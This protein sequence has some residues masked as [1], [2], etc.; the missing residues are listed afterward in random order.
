[1]ADVQLNIS[2]EDWVTISGAAVHVTAADLLVDNADRRGGEPGH[3]RALVHDEGDVLTVNFH[4]DYSGG[5]RLNDA[6]LRLHVEDQT[7]EHVRLPATAAVG[8]LRLLRLR[9]PGEVGALH[10]TIVSLWVC[11]GR[12]VLRFGPVTWVPLVLGEA[13]LGEGE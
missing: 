3:R 8:E 6:L 5:L 4:D 12:P 7:G 10:G 9:R 13:V 1:M 2:G 11:V